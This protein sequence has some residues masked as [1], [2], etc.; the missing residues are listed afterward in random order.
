MLDV[1]AL[2]VT[3]RLFAPE[4]DVQAV[5]VRPTPRRNGVRPGDTAKIVL[6]LLRAEGPKTSR[7]L[8]EAVMAAR[9]V[10]RADRKL[11]VI[12]RNRVMSSLREMEKRGGLRRDEA[13]RW[14]YQ[15]QR[16]LPPPRGQTTAS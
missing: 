10:S 12:M 13:G 7:E 9:D 5:K 3:I 14:L 8:I 16:P 15:R 6:D 2:D 4:I 11:Y 1:D